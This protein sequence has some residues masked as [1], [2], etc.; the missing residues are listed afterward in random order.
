MFKSGHISTHMIDRG[1]TAV[2][3]H[4][5]SLEAEQGL[6]DHGKVGCGGGG[7]YVLVI[8]TMLSQ[9]MNQH[10]VNQT[11]KSI[12]DFGSLVHWHGIGRVAA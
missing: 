7:M 11:F 3:G 12:F 1:H 10:A 8:M 9:L 6:S 4:F 5:L 2:L